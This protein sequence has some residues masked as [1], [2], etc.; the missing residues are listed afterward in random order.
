[1]TETV[2]DG[3]SLKKFLEND[4]LWAKFIGERF[5]ILD[6]D[7]TGKLTRSDLEPAI[8]GV[9][10]A[11]GLPPM[12]SS[13]ETDH[14]YT[15]MFREFGPEGEGITKQTFSNVMRDILMGLGDGLEREPVAF[16]SLDGHKLERWARSPEF[17]IEAVTAF[18]ALDADT[19]GQL[20]AAA[21]KKAMRR[22]SVDQGMPP[23][24]NVVV[25][26]FIDTALQEA[27]VNV[28]QDLDQTQFVDVYRKVVLALV[29]FLK[30]KPVSVAHTENVFDGASIRQLIKDKQALDLALSLAWEIMPKTSNGSAPKSYLRVGLDTLAPYA[31]LPPVGAVPEIDSV[32][33]ET[34]KMIDDDADGKVDKPGFDKYMVE[35]LGGVMLQLEGKPVG[36]ASS[37]VVSPEKEGVINSPI[38]SDMI[39]I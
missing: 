6:K 23:Q 17:E 5:A 31:G 35:V 27:G 22:V 29:K 16:S 8:S 34:F 39:P 15:E 7:H 36:V 13:P 3:K 24:T 19:S 10:K 33:N 14:I 12:G 30:D 18:G 1:M 9:G 37:A 11:L 4:Q 25:S 26:N 28:E 2:M 20:K 38:N 32:V 21:I